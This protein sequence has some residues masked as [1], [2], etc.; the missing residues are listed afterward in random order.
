MI[1]SKRLKEYKL[2]LQD[3]LNKEK[4]KDNFESWCMCIRLDAEISILEKLLKESI[5]MDKFGIIQLK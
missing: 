3:F 5:E 2:I 4:E 1:T